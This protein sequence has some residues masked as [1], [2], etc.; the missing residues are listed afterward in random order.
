MTFSPQIKIT[1]QSSE[2]TAKTLSYDQGHWD[3][4]AFLQLQLINLLQI[5][6]AQLQ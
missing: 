1:K 4:V 2:K 5:C 3:F 6:M